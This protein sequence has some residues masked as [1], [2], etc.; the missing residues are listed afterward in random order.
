[1]MT[2]GS[3]S[4]MESLSR[5]WEV[6]LSTLTDRP[7]KRQPRVKS[8]RFAVDHRLTCADRVISERVYRSAM[9]EDEAFAILDGERGTA[10]D[11]ACVDALR[12]LL[13]VSARAAA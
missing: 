1:V 12:E 13:G 10:F 3:S 4:A 2:T 7:A 11:A 6:S 5:Q 8:H 9:P